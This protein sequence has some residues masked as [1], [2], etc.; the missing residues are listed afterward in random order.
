MTFTELPLSVIC[1]PHCHRSLELSSGMR[2]N[3]SQ[4]GLVGQINSYGFIE[5]IST[6]AAHIDSTTAEYARLQ[7]DSGIRVYEEYLLPYLHQEPFRRVLDVGCGLGKGISRLIEADYDAYGVDLPQVSQY[8]EQIGNNPRNFICCDA[9]EIP[10]P[11]DYFDVVYSLGVIEHIGTTDGNGRLADNYWEIRQRYADEILRITV[12]NGRILI[13]CPN[14]SF[15]IDIQHGCSKNSKIRYWVYRKTKLHFHPIWGKNHLLSYQ[16]VK[17]LFCKNRA[18]CAIQ[19][20]PLYRYFGFRKLRS[21]A[22][23]PLSTVVEAY[24]NH[25]PSFLRASFLNP[26]ILVQIRK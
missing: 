20:L 16:E 6:E 1:C 14:K 26:Y 5:L 21:S 9:T 24:L 18:N 7:E 15:P 4:C 8:W 17:Q 19:P 3:C 23:K 12:P 13:A 10:F 11:D 2:L 22:L 25:L